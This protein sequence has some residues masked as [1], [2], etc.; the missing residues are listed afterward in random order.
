MTEPVIT[1]QSVID[2]LEKLAYARYDLND[3]KDFEI[4]HRALSDVKD[5]IYKIPEVGEVLK[6]DVRS[7]NATD[8]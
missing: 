5:A 1:K 2:E 8:I 7:R 6:S 4:Y 3:A